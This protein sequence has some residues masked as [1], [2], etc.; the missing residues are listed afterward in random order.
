[1]ATIAGALALAAA[2]LGPESV[3]SVVAAHAE[4]VFLDTLAVTCAAGRADL[5]RGMDDG[6]WWGASESGPSTVLS[7]GR[8]ASPVAAGALNAACGNID[9][10][11]EG[12]PVRGH[13]AIHLVPA[14]LAAAEHLGS[15]GPE[16]LAALVAGYE[17]TVRVGAA[18]GGMRAS[19]HSNAGRNTIG[20]AAAVAYLASSRDAA[21]IASAIET[22]ASVTTLAPWALASQG[23]DAYHLV[24]S[25]GTA[26]GMLAGSNAALG[27]S[28]PEGMIEN[29]FGPLA[30]R[31]FGAERAVDDLDDDGRWTSLRIM[32]NHFKLYPTCSHT[33][34]AIDAAVELHQEGV[35]AADVL[36]VEAVIVSGEEEAI[37]DRS[38]RNLF[39]ARYSVPL[40]VATA[41][42]RGEEGVISMEPSI[43]EDREIRRIA[44]ATN[45]RRDVTL[46]GT[47]P[48]ARPAIVRVSLPGGSQ[49]E[50][51]V[52]APRGEPENPLES[53]VMDA[54]IRVLFA[55]RYGDAH[56][57]RVEQI[58]R[59]WLRGRCDVAEVSATL[60]AARLELEA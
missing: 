13:P 11:G 38:P 23:V 60:R 41:L 37:Y 25:V 46:R 15:S 43:L 10:L 52:A 5:I 22:A 42:V 48:T 17:V 27:W 49:R 58:V 44:T 6:G 35:D 56:G 57:A 29:H 9:L 55:D 20:V 2:A 32:A 34:G 16:A 7:S 24:S 3:D 40:L 53:V 36:G 31:E 8:G 45:V 4:T 54:K 33:H 1:M 14:V 39:A 47:D 12:S 28:G 50:H 30:S 21:V 51:A 19:L 26:E 18:M 59:S